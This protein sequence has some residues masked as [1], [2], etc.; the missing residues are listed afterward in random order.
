MCLTCIKTE[1]TKCVHGECIDHECWICMEEL[2][3]EEIVMN[4]ELS[5]IP[6]IVFDPEIE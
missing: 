5:E 4:E 6:F 3:L 2:I 1:T